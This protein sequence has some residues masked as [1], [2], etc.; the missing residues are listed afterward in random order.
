MRLMKNLK[1]HKF[2]EKPDET[3]TFVMVR[4]KWFEDKRLGRLT[5]A[6]FELL[7]IICDKVNPFNG[8]ATV[9]H[10]T[11]ADEVRKS[12]NHVTKLMS[13]LK[14]KGYIYFSKHNGSR[15]SFQVLIHG[16]KLADKDSWVDINPNLSED[17]F[18]ISSG[19]NTDET[20]EQPQIDEPLNQN[21]NTIKDNP[22]QVY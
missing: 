14:K 22:H 11:L 7:V 3:K 21:S 8:Y 1:I 15:A 19:A 10:T 20:T 16:Y 4:K 6:E 2:N 18:I 17:G 12:V 9:T 5:R 13:E